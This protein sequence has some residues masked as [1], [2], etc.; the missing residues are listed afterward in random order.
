MKKYKI[1]IF[2]AG[3]GVDDSY[4]FRKLNCEIVALCDK[5][6]E[7][8]KFGL[9]RLGDVPTYTD[10]D[11]FLDSGIDAVVIAN[12]FHEHTPYIIKCFEKGIHVY[13][14]CIASGTLAEAV[15]LMRAYKKNTKSIFFL[16]ENYPQ[17]RYNLE[18]QKIC[19]GG[20][21]GKLLY[22]EG[23]YCHPTDP[24]AT[25]FLKQFIHYPKHW[26]N[27]LPRTYYLTHSLG[28]VMS[29]TGASP[30]KVTAFAAF[31]APEGDIAYGKQM[32]DQVAIITTQNDDGS[33]FRFTGCAAFGAHHR[34]CR[35]CGTEGQVE[36]IRGMGDN[37]IMLRYNKWSI[38]EGLKEDNLIDL[39]WD[40]PDAELIKK[41]G[42]GGSDYVTS[43][44]FLQCI[45]ENRQPDFP[46]NLEAAVVMSETAI[47]AHR[48]MLDGGKPY[49]IPDF[50]DE[51]VCKL[52]ENDRLSPFYG[53]DGSE[54]TLPCCSHPDYKPEE[55]QYKKY[56]EAIGYTEE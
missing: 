20:T 17:T 11:E 12:D 34:S 22:A 45:E 15:E 35:V 4:A 33:I 24:N 43:R 30:K 39:E 27:Y 48:S 7:R 6:D 52:Y 55:R 14:E 16:A 10:F 23:E 32:A 21:L 13:C 25:G 44:M 49:D 46:L 37:K 19:K 28:P 53:S 2:G 38:P 26:R 36:S 9:S 18:I 3:R 31:A 1:G 50:T 56:L 40:D 42:H 5:N 29:A 41:S 8:I 47:L 54:P 51:E